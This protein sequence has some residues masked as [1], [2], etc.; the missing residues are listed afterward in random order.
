MAVLL[1]L[2]AN[3]PNKSQLLN[4]P[5]STA[6]KSLQQFLLQTRFFSCKA[7]DLWFS[8]CNK[9]T[10]LLEY[11]YMCRHISCSVWVKLRGRSGP[12][13]GSCA[14]KY[15]HA[16]ELYLLYYGGLRFSVD[17]LSTRSAFLFW[18]AHSSCETVQT[19][20]CSAMFL[21]S[22]LPTSRLKWHR[23]LE[24]RTVT[25]RPIYYSNFQ[26]SF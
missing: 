24:I 7:N 16:C 5:V 25:V 3:K 9:T 23:I 20:L 12:R 14:R 17:C 15:T 22:R 1:L 21:P 2:S 11:H 18:P 4:F 6:S 13:L 26:I 8:A 10:V 19:F